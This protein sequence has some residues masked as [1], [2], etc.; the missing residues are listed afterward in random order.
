MIRTGVADVEHRECLGDVDRMEQFAAGA[1]RVEDRG[2]VRVEFPGGDLVEQQPFGFPPERSR[3][4]RRRS[5]R[6]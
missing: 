1:D 4:G 6:L 2:Q 5:R 3:A